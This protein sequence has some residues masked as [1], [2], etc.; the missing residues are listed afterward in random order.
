[1]AIKTLII[2]DAALYRKIIGDAL[3]TYPDIEI[4][5]R[6]NSGDIALAMMEQ[7]PVDLVFCDV[8]MPG[9]DGVETLI[10]IR[11]RFPFVNVIMMSGV[12]T[13]AADIT[14]RALELGA[15]DFIQKPKGSSVQENFETL[16]NDIG[17]ILRLVNIRR[18]NAVAALSVTTH[19]LTQTA[20]A[21][22]QAGLSGRLAFPSSPLTF[23]V[24]AI[25]VST[26]GPEALSK[27][28]PALPKDLPVPV[29]LVQHMP[30]NFTKSLAESLARK[31]HISVVEARIGDPV[32]NGVVFLAP[33]GHHM[34]V[35]KGQGNEKLIGINDLP[36]ENS[37][38]PS[39]DVLFRSI[40]DIYGEKGILSVVLTGMGS[41]GLNGVR[42]MKRKG[43][44]CITQNE[45]TCVIYGMPKTIADAGM[46]DVSLPIETI[47][48]EICRKL[49]C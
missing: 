21:V 31:S 18:K 4:V 2:D 46:S 42:A 27:L 25:G 37:C 14:V 12:A 43:C 26:G 6:A 48:Q 38:R 9:K 39:V 45:S 36:P 7:T 32:Q 20:L 8:Y 49:K 13:R 30:Q 11:K 17:G 40:A 41:D 47:A 15:L 1:M 34:T 24:C 16:K 3:E 22:Q 19:P 23:G 10:E 29:F 28:I 5:N 44:Y 33:G 35:R